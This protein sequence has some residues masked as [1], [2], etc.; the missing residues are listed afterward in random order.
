VSIDLFDAKSSDSVKIE[1][2]KFNLIVSV[3][4]Y[5]SGFLIPISSLTKE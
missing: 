5:H 3:V 2:D 4:S 1:A